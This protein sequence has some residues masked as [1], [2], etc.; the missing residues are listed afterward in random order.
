MAQAGAT[1]NQRIFD[2]EMRNLR[3]QGLA[4]EEAGRR[5]AAA[6]QAAQLRAEAGIRATQALTREQRAAEEAARGATRANAEAEREFERA[7]ALARRTAERGLGTGNREAERARQE[8]LRAAEREADANARRLDRAVERFGDSL[9]DVTYT[10]LEDGA[11]RGQDVF[12]SLATGFG[13]LLRRAAVEALSVTVMQPLVRDL[14]ST[15]GFTG[16]ATGQGSGFGA[17]TD[18]LG[19]GSL[20]G[21]GGLTGAIDAFG[22]ASGLAGNGVTFAA[23][24]GAASYGGFGA[25]GEGAVSGLLG[26]GTLS[27]ALGGIGLGFGA[28]SMVGSLVAGNSPARQTNGM[29]GAGI[30]SLAGVGL[31]AA[32]GGPIGLVAAGLLGGVAGGAGGGLLGPG[33]KT[34]AFG[35]ALS[36]A[37][38][39]FSVDGYQ[40]TGNGAGGAEALAQT[41]ATIAQLNAT[42]AANNIAVA[43]NTRVINGQVDSA[44]QSRDLASALRQFSFSSGDPILGKALNERSFAS[45]EELAT[46]LQAPQRYAAVFA[47]QVSRGRVLGG[48]LDQVSLST[49]SA[50]SQFGAAQAQFEAAITAAR[51]AG[52]DAADLSRVTQSGATLLQANSAYYGSGAQAAAIERMVKST[53]ISLGGELDLPGFADDLSGAIDRAS[54]RAQNAAQQQQVTLEALREE[55]RGLRLV[56]ERSLA[57]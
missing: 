17:L 29:I 5:A 24:S 43:D 9:A 18:L 13:S 36:A 51:V 2:Q 34:N 40:Q 16:A 41:R 37:G 56:I 19:L 28:G 46:A 31:A 21:S 54:D 52:P 57:A 32:L 23:N 30:G 55:V 8:A 10:A 42:L 1:A 26:T 15:I 35:F 53:V 39:Q 38:G 50:Q 3:D 44:D 22:V 45:L 25:A 14:A 6:A 4:E 12:Q 33:A 7:E 27:S 49:G 11:L 20:F 48:F 47:N